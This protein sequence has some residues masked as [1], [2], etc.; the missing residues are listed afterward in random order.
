MEK[1]SYV[2]SRAALFF[3]KNFKDGVGCVDKL[4]AAARTY[5]KLKDE[6]RTKKQS[7]HFINMHISN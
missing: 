2:F 6:L 1:Y 7:F 3:Q 5:G 4:Q